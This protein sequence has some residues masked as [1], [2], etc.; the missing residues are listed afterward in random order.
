MS[1]NP[2][3]LD[4]FRLADELVIELYQA[5]RTF[6]IEERYG[7]SAQLRRAAVSTASNIV[8]GCARRS[9]AEYL[10]FLNIAAGSAFEARYLTDASFRLGYL[11]H[12]QYEALMPQQ[13]RLAKSIIR[14]IASLEPSTPK[15]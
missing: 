13:T 14:L 10:H 7:L 8:E 4:V 11:K 15:A 2:E 5:T 6:P 1:R 12:T 9:T 3:K